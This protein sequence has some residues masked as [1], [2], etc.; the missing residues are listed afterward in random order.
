MYSDT[1]GETKIEGL[2]VLKGPLTSLP[3]NGVRT[4]RPTVKVR[5]SRELQSHV[6]PGPLTGNNHEI[7][8]VSLVKDSPRESPRDDGHLTL[9]VDPDGKGKRQSNV[10]ERVVGRQNK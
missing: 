4:K 1:K 10:H 3:Y 7:G 2:T 6:S 5:S 8:R 9:G